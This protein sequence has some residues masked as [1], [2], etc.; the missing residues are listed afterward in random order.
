MFW[1][2]HATIAL[3]I[4]QQTSS[5]VA[6]FFGGYISH[7]A[8]DAIPHGD[9]LILAWL[10]KRHSRTRSLALM[11]IV[12]SAVLCCWFAILAY[13]GLLPVSIVAL[14]AVFGSLLPDWLTGIYI[15]THWKWLGWN[16]WLN[17][18]AHKLITKTPVSTPIGVSL[19]LITIVIATWLLGKT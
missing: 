9:E 10:E 16:N 1:T 11:A 17:N 6:G 13:F 3:V 18:R 19:Q 14:A 15:L 5:P 7:F 4:A 2:A 12:D 8:L